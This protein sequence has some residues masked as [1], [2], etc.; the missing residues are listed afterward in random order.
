MELVS[1]L[2]QDDGEGSIYVNLQ[3]FSIF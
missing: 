3:I 1:L 2:A